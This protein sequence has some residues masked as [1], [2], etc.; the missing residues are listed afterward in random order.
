MF[1]AIKKEKNNKMVCK[2]IEK[3]LVTYN[4]YVL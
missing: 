1:Y 4:K 2:K 3:Y